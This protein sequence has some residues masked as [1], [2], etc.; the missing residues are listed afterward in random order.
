M[1]SNAYVANPRRNNPS[2]GGATGFTRNRDK[3]VTLVTIRDSGGFASA[4]SSPSI[5]PAATK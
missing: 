4:G 3:I 5:H 1:L 2:F